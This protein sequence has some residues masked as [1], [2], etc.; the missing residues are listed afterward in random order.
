M[1]TNTSKTLLGKVTELAFK[2][3]SSHNA[4]EAKK[5]IRLFVYQRTPQCG[6]T[7]RT[8]IFGVDFARLGRHLLLLSDLLASSTVCA[9]NK[10]NTTSIKEGV[11]K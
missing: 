2:T 7:W 1:G 4:P 5:Q 3:Y 6:K 11:V 9:I 8:E 10:S